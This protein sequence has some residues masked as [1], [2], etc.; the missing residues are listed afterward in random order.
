MPMRKYFSALLALM[1]ILALSCGALADSGALEPSEDFYVNDQAGT[2][3]ASTKELID[4]A[5]GPLEQECDGA[6][7]VVVTIN[8][9]PSG[10][11]SEQYACSSSTTGASA[12]IPPTMACC[13][14]TSCR[15]TA[16]G[17]QSARV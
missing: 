3:S 1:L 4:N 11:D 17:S 12:A 16:A 5:S 10:Y 14:S 2:L 9:L 6:Q 13:C 7:I 8:Y 15:R